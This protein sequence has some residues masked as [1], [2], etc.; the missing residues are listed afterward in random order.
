M[1]KY[2]LIQNIWSKKLLLILKIKNNIILL[3]IKSKKRTANLFFKDL[4]QHHFCFLH[5]VNY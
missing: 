1:E 2:F 5:G 3:K 4:N